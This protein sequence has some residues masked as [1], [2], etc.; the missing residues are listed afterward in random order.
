MDKQ[1]LKA[2]IRTIVEEEVKRILPEMLS[3]AVNQVKKLSENTEVSTTPKKSTLDRKRLAA[4]IGYDGET[5]VAN[6]SAVP[7]PSNVPP[8]VDPAV[9]TAVT[10]DYSELMKKL[11]LS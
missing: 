9:V 4:L 10:R 8:D 2:Y 7:L 3:E 5:M 6:T 11:K 1:L